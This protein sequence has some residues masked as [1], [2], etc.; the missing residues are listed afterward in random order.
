MNPQQAAQLRNAGQSDKMASEDYIQLLRRVQG[1]LAYLMPRA[2]NQN[3]ETGAGPKVL[4]GPAFM[5]HPPQMPV[6]REK[7]E[8]LRKLFPDWVG[9]DAKLMAMSS[10]GSAGGGSPAQQQQGQQQQQQ[11]AN[12]V[13]TS[14]S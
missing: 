13:P 9:N 8:R 5:Q 1:N 7:Y 12:G 2:G 4:P 3:N 6:L 10:S 14:T 11:S